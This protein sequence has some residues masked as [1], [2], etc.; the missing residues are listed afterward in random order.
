MP[1]DSARITAGAE[2]V[3]IVAKEPWE[4]TLEEY[5]RLYPRVKGGMVDGRT[6][7][8]DIPNTA[9]IE[10]SLNYPTILPGVREVPMSEFDDSPGES[11]ERVKMLA[12][13]IRESGEINPL[14]VV[15]QKDG[16][17]ILE[18][19]HRFEALKRLKAK[20]LPALVVLDGESFYHAI[21][22][23]LAE[24]KKVS[25]E[26]LKQ[27]PDFERAQTAGAKVVMVQPPDLC[28]MC[29]VATGAKEPWEMT[30]K[31][32][33]NISLDKW[34]KGKV[35]EIESIEAGQIVFQDGSGGELIASDKGDHINLSFIN[36]ETKGSGLGSKIINAIKEFSNKTG[37]TI[38]VHKPY[39]EP[40]WKKMG[41]SDYGDGTFRWN[42]TEFMPHWKIVQNA[43]SDGKPVPAEV[44]EDY[45]DLKGEIQKGVRRGMGSRARVMR[46]WVAGAKVLRTQPPGTCEMCGKADELRPYGPGGMR[47]CFEC[48]MLDEEEAGRQFEKVLN[49]KEEKIPSTKYMVGIHKSY[50]PEAIRPKDIGEE[51]YETVIVPAKSRADA[52]RKAWAVRGEEWLGLMGPKQTSV[53]RVSLHVDEPGTTHTMGR[54]VPITVYRE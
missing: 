4:M 46:L 18:G 19:I 17:W 39:N 33:D 14:I 42:H 34:V 53:R 7:R 38:I 27:Y 36:L 50:F 47:V 23:A 31:E 40:F 3:R 13:A 54:L 32:Y 6:V 9:S 24:G 49:A 16:P 15:V 48:A 41:F 28:E 20:A 26:V 43:L 45:P 5:D 11:S 52:A 2:G 12:R 21:K 51:F 8:K 37:E 29:E 44:L 10:A 35:P 25:P 30:K 22:K 1:S